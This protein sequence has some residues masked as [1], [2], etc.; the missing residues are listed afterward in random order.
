MS[1]H[2]N[3]L[4]YKIFLLINNRYAFKRV[5][6]ICKKSD[7]NM[8]KTAVFKNSLLISTNVTWPVMKCRLRCNV[9]DYDI[10]Y[11]TVIIIIL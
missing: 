7:V 8:N 10:V 6:K 9:A 1:N 2:Y 5:D 4:I 3:R 11:A